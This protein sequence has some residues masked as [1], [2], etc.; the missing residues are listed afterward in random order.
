MSFFYYDDKMRK[1][2]GK[3]NFTPIIFHLENLFEISPNEDLLATLIGVAW[4]YCIEGN[5]NQTPIDYDWRLYLYKWKQYIDLGS[6]KFNGSEKF[7]YIAGYT[8]SLH[9]FYI[10]ES[11]KKNGLTLMKKCFEICEDKNLKIIAQNFLKNA[12]KRNKGYIRIKNF[13]NICKNLFPT[14]SMLDCY[15]KEIYNN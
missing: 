4:Y 15:F 14:N 11:Y 10:S 5:V 2:E 8:L 13:E 7:C 6:E 3:L 1:Y 12:N 9:G